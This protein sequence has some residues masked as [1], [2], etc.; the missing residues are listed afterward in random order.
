MNLLLL[1]SALLSALN[2]VGVG[3]RR[4]EL[5]QS[6]SVQA[7]AAQQSGAAV[8]MSVRRPVAA[9]PTLLCAAAFDR[10]AAPVLLGA[11]DLWANRR[12]E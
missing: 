12:R 5:A 11:G 9:L 4:Q 2:G 7:I 8:Q 6:V 1:L 3:V 10:V